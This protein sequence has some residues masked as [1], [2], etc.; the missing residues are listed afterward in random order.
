MPK[1]KSQEQF[2]QECI[3]I[4]QN[5]D[6][7][8][9]Q[10]KGSKGKIIIICPRHGEVTV[11]AGDFLKSGKCPKCGNNVPTTQEFIN[12]CRAFYPEYDYSKV[13]YVTRNKPVIVRCKKHDYTWSPLA[14]NL[15]RGQAMCPLCKS[16]LYKQKFTMSQKEYIDRC[17]LV[18]NNKYDYSKTIYRGM[19]NKITITCPIHGDFEQ[20]ASNHIKGSGCPKCKRSKG[21]EQV[22]SLLNKLGIKY[23]EQYVIYPDNKHKIIVDFYLPEH[24]TFIEY[25]GIQ[26]YIPIKH[27][28]GELRFTQ[29]T[30][31]DNILRNY[32]KI[33]SIK[34]IEI[35][36]NENVVEYL[37]SELCGREDFFKPWRD[38][39]SKIGYS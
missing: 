15:E 25:N 11:T 27:F 39:N 29:Q 36:Y 21:E 10:Y 22:I 16:E 24:N 32:C 31:R 4:N 3:N 19:D 8:K 12:K 33:N 35:K 18:H 17:I 37:E 6:Y 2:I 20:M 34:L 13:I 14:E 28:G 5:L 1:R 23:I 7:S 38:S 9:V 30:E 26:H